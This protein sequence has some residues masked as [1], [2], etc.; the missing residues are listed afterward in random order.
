[1]APT[2]P[3]AIR[4]AR[5][6]DWAPIAALLTASDLPLDG[7]REHLGGFIIAERDGAVVG[8]AA[9]ERHGDAGLLRSVAVTDGERGRGTGRAL[10]AEAL[11]A[12]GEARLTTIALLTT[13]AAPYFERLGFRTVS[14]DDVP[15]S[16][17]ASAEFRGACPAS[18]TVMRL[19]LQRDSSG[20][21]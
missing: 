17:H 13:T 9:V 14:R 18:A 5:P 4:P 1:M 15:S 2:A 11:R 10:V 21:A 20:S 16:L 19:D 8:C 12:A 3:T 6:D 7:A